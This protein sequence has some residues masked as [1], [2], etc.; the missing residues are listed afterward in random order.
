MS[1]I[2]MF[3]FL[4]VIATHILLGANLFGGL[5]GILYATAG[6]PLDPRAMVLMG[7]V[8]L[9]TL[10]A[11]FAN[12]TGAALGVYFY[13][14]VIL[15]VVRMLRGRVR[16]FDLVLALM[17]VLGSFALHAITGAFIVAGFAPALA[18][19]A[20]VAAWLDG[21]LQMFSP[22]AMLR[23]F[24]AQVANPSARIDIALATVALL[25]LGLPVLLLG[26]WIGVT[27][28]G[29]LDDTAFR[30]AILVLLLISGLSLVV[31]AFFR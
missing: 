17:A 28:Y 27:L 30:K 19:A 1:R 6:M 25:L 5:Y 9:A 3:G 13:L 2:L 16:G 20:L 15:V 12:Y 23:W 4:V 14:F 22:R 11:K 10:V 21:K 24:Q 18:C 7:D 31:P 8:R 26:L 29:K